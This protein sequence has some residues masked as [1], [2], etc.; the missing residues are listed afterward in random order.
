MGL[1]DMSVGEAKA[2]LDPE[3]EQIRDVYAHYGLAMYLAQNVE[4]GLSMA[5]ALHG[6]ATHMT[7]W[8]FDARLAE[9]YQ[10]T[11]G[12]LVSK[13]LASSAA[14]SSE[15]TGR[16]QRANDL[17][18]DLAHQYFWYRAIQFASPEGQLAMIAELRQIQE[19]FESLDDD[20]SKIV[21]AQVE[22]RGEELASFRSRTEAS[23]NAFLSGTAVPRSPERVPNHVEVVA[24]Q[25]WQADPSKPGNLVLVSKEGRY[26][27]PGERGLC[28]GPPAPPAGTTARTLVLDRALPAKI[29]PRP[30]TTASFNYGIPLA[31]GYVLR[32]KTRPDLAAGGFYVWIQKPRPA[33]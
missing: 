25:V 31:N 28:Y 21:D 5:L 27:V 1:V 19:D 6:Q 20:L 13:F 23:L 15:L 3:S 7:A 16:L 8:D 26:L 22:G 12:E 9:N 24:A 10:A 17:R 4:R 2:E 11:F 18:N 32:A 14:A 30:K 33:E 29:D